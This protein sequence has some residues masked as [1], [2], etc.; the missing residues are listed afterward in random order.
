MDEYL[1]KDTKEWCRNKLLE[2]GYERG[3]VSS[4]EFDEAVQLRVHEKAYRQLRLQVQSYLDTNTILAETS[5]P[6]GGLGWEPPLDKV[7][8]DAYNDCLAD[9]HAPQQMDFPNDGVDEQAE[10]SDFNE[11]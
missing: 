2:L 6:Y 11:K 7:T 9:P 4:T 8:A 3:E 10:L 5:A 1:P